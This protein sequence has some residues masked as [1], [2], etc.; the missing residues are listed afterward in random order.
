MDSAID[1]TSRRPVGMS[2][3]D[4]TETWT[5]LASQRKIK[6]CVT[7]AIRGFLLNQVT[8]ADLLSLTRVKHLQLGNAIVGAA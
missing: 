8:Y 3:N 4:A 1:P 6:H 2:A 5:T 7:F